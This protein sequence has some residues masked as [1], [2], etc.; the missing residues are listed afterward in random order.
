MLRDLQAVLRQLWRA[1][2]FVIT[3]SLTLA[4]GVGAN[5]AIFSVV[6]GFMRPLP[7]PHPEQIVVVA[8]TMAGDETGL[9]YRFS[10][11]AIK[12]YRERVTVFS[13]V[14]GFDIRL[15]GLG[16]NGKTTQFIHHA[17][18]GNYFQALGLQ[19]AAGRLIAPG[20]GEQANTDLVVVLAYNYWKRTFGGN[21]S[22]I[23]TSVKFDGSPA[24]IIG[25]APEGFKGLTEGAEMDGYVPLSLARRF[26]PRNDEFFLDRKIRRLTMVARMK[27]GVSIEEAQTVVNSV[28]AQ[29]VAEHPVEEKGTGARVIPEPLARPMPWPVL[30]SLLPLI[31]YFLLVLSLVVLLI[32]CLNVANI[33]LVR[34]TVREREMAVRASLGAG[35]ARLMRLLLIESLL[36]AVFGTSLGLGIGKVMSLMFIDSVNLGM[37]IAFKLDAHFDWRVFTYSAVATLVTAFAVGA[38]PAR[39][40]SRANVTGLLHDGGRSGSISKARMRIRNAL[41]IAQV[42]G[43]LVL[44][45]I[46]GLFVRNLTRAQQLDLGFDS[47]HIVSARLDTLNIG[48]TEARSNAFYDELHRRLKA[49]PGVESASLSFNIPLSWIIGGYIASPTDQREPYDTPLPAIGCSSVSPEYFST[50]KIPILRGRGFTDADRMGAKRVAIVNEVLADRWWPGQDPLGKRIDV[51]ATSGDP[52]EIVGVAKTSKYM[53]VFETPLPY[54]YVPQQQNPSWLRSIMVRSSMPADELKLRIEREI[55]A[56]E[57]EM[58]IADLKT[59]DELIAGNIGFVLFRVGA[60]QA[61]SMGI[62][63][64]ALAVIG[65]YGVVSYQTKQREKEIGI[66]MALGAVPGDV[67]KLVLGQGA[68]LVL[69]GTAIGLAITLASTLALGRMIVL[70]S[71]TD[72][73][74]FV[75]VTAALA[76]SALV[77]CYVPAM[78]ATRVEPVTV[79][80]QE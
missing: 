15:A 38:L 20:E 63:G 39:R 33:M 62:L 60:W 70:V 25:V 19:P 53:A 55:T 6:N 10:F 79:L 2:S 68:R 42:A 44:L 50:L 72:P 77:A 67:R 30:S 27:P 13:D 59:V 34:V 9:R 57:P 48:L 5:T 49:L 11:P 24:Q 14:F 69:I 47:H 76:S 32:A 21:P 58:P 8:T 61:S 74:T 40:A 17:V 80:R 46:A 3:A 66:R 7:V 41:V 64:L 16:I 4:L 52:W 26:E 37:D 71:T 78:R 56:L 29:L 45:I 28:A 35:R 12:D 65:V 1:P 22:V 23:G 43:S 36:L 73:L 54:F 31:R 18:T 51:P 75:V